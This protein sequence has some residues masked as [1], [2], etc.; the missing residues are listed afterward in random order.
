MKLNKWTEE[1][2]TIWKYGVLYQ[3]L[4]S[5][6]QRKGGQDR[7]LLDEMCTQPPAPTPSDQSFDISLDSTFLKYLMQR[8]KIAIISHPVLII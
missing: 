8:F 5:P 7:H 6:D 3:S 1:F 2:W 4:P